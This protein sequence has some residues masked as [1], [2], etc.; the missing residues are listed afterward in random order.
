MAAEI[1][2]GIHQ[3]LVTQPAQSPDLKINDLGIFASLASRAWGMNARTIEDLVKTIFE[4]YEEYDGDTLER[5]WQ[6]LKVYNQTLRKFADNDVSVENTGARVRQMAVTLERV[7][8][9][10]VG[11]FQRAWDFLA[12]S[13]SDGEDDYIYIYFFFFP[14]FP[15]YFLPPGKGA[16]YGHF[17]AD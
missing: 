10:D 1:A 14:F 6:I 16:K 15:R 7:V 17:G 13:P 5:V 3:E 8:K 11:A 4:Q 12:S 9:Y 2:M